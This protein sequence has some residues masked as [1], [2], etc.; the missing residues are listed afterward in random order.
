MQIHSTSSS[1]FD[2]LEWFSYEMSLLDYDSMTQQIKTLK[3]GDLGPKSNCY[4]YY[5]RSMTPIL[6]Y[7]SPPVVYLGSD[8]AFWIDP[9]SS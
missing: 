7:L 3:C 4:V 2:S 1:Q 8:V 9:R 6:Y 5:S